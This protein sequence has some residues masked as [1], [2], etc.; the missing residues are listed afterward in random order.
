L[1]ALGSKVVLARR[2]STKRPQL[3]SVAE[4]EQRA[5]KRYGTLHPNV[6]AFLERRK[7][8]VAKPHPGR[9]YCP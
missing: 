3:T 8:W 7:G 1:A 4:A 5:R 9:P 6:T 2:R